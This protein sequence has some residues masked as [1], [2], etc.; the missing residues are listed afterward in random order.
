MSCSIAAQTGCLSV[1][2]AKL[3]L[4]VPAPGTFVAEDDTTSPWTPAYFQG[5]GWS[6]CRAPDRVR[7]W[8][9]HGYR[10]MRLAR[11][12]STMDQDWARAV[13]YLAAC[14]LDRPLCQCA[15]LSPFIDWLNVDRAKSESSPGGQSSSY[16]NTVKV[17]DC[18]FGTKRGELYAYE[19]VMRRNLAKD[20]R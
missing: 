3:G 11:P 18:P 14:K 4:I 13:A 6:L 20:P 12:E 17:L 16:A 15:N 8:Y 19:F 5:G 1:A 7:L 2:D 9:K 10:N